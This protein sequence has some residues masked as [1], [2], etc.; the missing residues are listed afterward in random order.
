MVKTKIWPVSLHF[1][2]DFGNTRYE[3]AMQR[4]SKDVSYVIVDTVTASLH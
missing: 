2:T 3:I 1:M 4:C